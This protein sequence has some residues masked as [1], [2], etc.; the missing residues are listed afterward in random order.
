MVQFY[1]LIAET[2]LDKFFK[3]DFSAKIFIYCAQ[4]QSDSKPSKDLEEHNFYNFFYG[5]WNLETVRFSPLRFRMG[6]L[7]FIFLM[8]QILREDIL[9]KYF[10]SL[11]PVKEMCI[12]REG[13][14]STKTPDIIFLL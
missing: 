7:T 14:S 2:I 3:L 13:N 8:Q 12:T 11:L 5:G 6:V 1:W 10:L 9:E 4:N